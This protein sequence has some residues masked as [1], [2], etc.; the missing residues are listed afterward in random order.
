MEA[1]HTDLL[2]EASGTPGQLAIHRN[3]LC[4]HERFVDAQHVIF[5]TH[6]TKATN[7]AHFAAIDVLAG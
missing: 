3:T 6:G 7:S 5:L 2:G 4:F 1:S